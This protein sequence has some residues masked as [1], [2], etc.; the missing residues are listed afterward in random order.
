[1]FKTQ[2]TTFHEV[3]DTGYKAVKC[4]G[5]CGRGVRRQKTFSQTLNPWN[6]KENG[7]AK[8]PNDI[9]QE[10]MVEISKWRKLPETCKHC[11]EE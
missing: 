9:Y 11:E 6:K 5:G 10:N 3:K 2:K 8:T 4:A 7:D 1:M